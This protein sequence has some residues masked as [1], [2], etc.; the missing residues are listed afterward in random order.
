M[1]EVS[2]QVEKKVACLVKISVPLLGG[3]PYS[4]IILSS[5]ILRC[6]Q[7]KEKSEGDG[8]FSVHRSSPTVLLV[9]MATAELCHDLK[10]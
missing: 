1:Q 7:T 5:S 8:S 10:G 2:K 6:F 4:S 9:Q 3:S